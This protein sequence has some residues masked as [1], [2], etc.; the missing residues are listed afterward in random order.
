VIHAKED[1]PSRL[2]HALQG[3]RADLVIVCAGTVSA[4]QQALECADRGATVLCFAPLEPG[5]IFS[6]PFFEVWND[7]IAL[8]STYGGAPFD[9]LTAIDLIRTRRLPIRQMI[10]HR[11]PLAES[12]MGFRLVAESQESIKVIIEPNR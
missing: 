9:L 12:A 6:L 5:L 8:V 4:Y 3:A 10:T 7:G 2:R 11:L 1:V